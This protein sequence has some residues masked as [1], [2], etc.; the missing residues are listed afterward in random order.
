MAKLNIAAEDLR[1]FED[2]TAED[3]AEDFRARGYTAREISY[4]ARTCVEQIG[5]ARRERKPR[6]LAS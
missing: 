4:L 1:G 2:W 6:R 3:F 5:K